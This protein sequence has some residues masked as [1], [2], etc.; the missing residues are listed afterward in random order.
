VR[1]T[2]PHHLTASRPSLRDLRWWGV[3]NTRTL[4]DIGP[5]LLRVKEFLGGQSSLPS[6]S[7]GG[8]EVIQVS[9]DL[10]TA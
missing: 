1:R 4:Y 7:S 8:L 10:G 3:V 5:K 6:G 2:H 9:R